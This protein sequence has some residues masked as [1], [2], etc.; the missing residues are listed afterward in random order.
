MAESHKLAVIVHHNDEVTV[1]DERGYPAVCCDCRFSGWRNEESYCNHKYP[2]RCLFY[3]GGAD[4]VDGDRI[5][6]GLRNKSSSYYDSRN[7]NG[8]EHD[9]KYP[10]C[11]NK[12]P[13]GNCPD[14][15]KAKPLPWSL[16]TFMLKLLH[17]EWR[18]RQMRL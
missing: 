6:E 10:L 1:L 13:E 8:G 9:A 2:P 7:W 3:S 18:T 15:V 11:A 12:N 5:M 14:Y 17:R 4:S 16:S